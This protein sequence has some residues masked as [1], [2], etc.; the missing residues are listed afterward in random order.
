LIA[1]IP[2]KTIGVPAEV[3]EAYHKNKYIQI[4][5]PIIHPSFA[6]YGNQMYLS[7]DDYIKRR[8]YKWMVFEK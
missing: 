6:V 1:W 2:E 7:I 8:Q 5:S 4:I 3:V